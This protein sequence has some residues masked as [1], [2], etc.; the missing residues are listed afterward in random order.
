MLRL[1]L[2]TDR[3]L[4]L[5]GT[6]THTSRKVGFGIRFTHL[7]EED[8]GMLALLNEYYRGEAVIVPAVVADELP[9]NTKQ[10]TPL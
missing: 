2:P 6:V 10:V 7:S 4:R 1:R 9:Q 8:R 5:Q 3:W